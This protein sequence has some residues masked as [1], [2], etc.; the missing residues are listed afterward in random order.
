[1]SSGR[2]R[3]SGGS[4]RRSGG[5]SSSSSSGP[6]EP[7]LQ[8]LSHPHLQD[9]PQTQA[10][11]PQRKILYELKALSALLLDMYAQSSAILTGENN[12]SHGLN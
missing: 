3:S 12:V 6:A 1:M 2:R 11:T 5:E 8:L 4:G 7:N 10:P 9:T